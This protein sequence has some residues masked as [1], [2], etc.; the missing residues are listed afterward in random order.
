MLLMSGIDRSGAA[1]TSGMRIGDLAGAL[2]TST[3]TLRHYERAGLLPPPARQSNG[4]RVYDRHAVNRARLVIGLRRIGL[5]IEEVRALLA[6]DEAGL[7][8]RLLGVLDRHIQEI[9]LQISILQGQ[10]DDLAAR[11]RALFDA[12]KNRPGSCVCDALS[13]PCGCGPAGEE[14]GR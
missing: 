11:Y 7:R 6:G 1:T 2:A 4:Y 9:G 3:K 8:Q 10:H 5:S 12:P 14:A 13:I